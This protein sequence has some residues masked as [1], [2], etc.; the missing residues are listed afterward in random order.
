MIDAGHMPAW[1][2]TKRFMER[3]TSFSPDALHVIAG[4]VIL[5]AAGLLMKRPLSSWW[6]WLFLLAIATLNE[7]VDLWSDQ[8]P[9]PGMQYG[10]SAKDLLLTMVVPTLLLLSTRYLRRLYEGDGSR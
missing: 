4:V 6:P 10:E 7:A 2:E 5:L 8:W 3:S 9:H 1:A